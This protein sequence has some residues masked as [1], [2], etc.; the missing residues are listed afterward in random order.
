MFDDAFASIARDGAGMLEVQLRLQK[1]L[2]ALASL[3]D[4]A[5]ES[6]AKRHS[7]L[8]LAR[9]GRALELTEEQESLSQAAQ[10]S[11]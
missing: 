7:R 2:Q 3:E 10:W 9:A 4:S 5:I 11:A 8:A 6:A 1:A